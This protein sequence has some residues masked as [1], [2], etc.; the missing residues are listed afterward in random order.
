M[1]TLSGTLFGRTSFFMPL[2]NTSKVFFF[3]PM[4][5]RWC[6]MAI[7]GVEVAVVWAMARTMLVAF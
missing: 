5:M 2:S 3:F 6:A 1:S 7:E 4:V